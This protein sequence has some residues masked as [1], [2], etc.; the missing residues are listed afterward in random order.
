MPS[1]TLCEPWF[2]GEVCSG[3]FKLSSL[4]RMYE[5]GLNIPEHHTSAQLN[6]AKYNRKV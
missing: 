6:D 3:M 1:Q 2:A 4:S 5:L